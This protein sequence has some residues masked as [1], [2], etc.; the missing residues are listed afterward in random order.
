MAYVVLWCEPVQLHSTVR[1]TWIPDQ[2][3]PGH[4]VFAVSTVGVFCDLEVLDKLQKV[5]IWVKIC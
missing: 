5:G 1:L 3:F 4:A 2:Q